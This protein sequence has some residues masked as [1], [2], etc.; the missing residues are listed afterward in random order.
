[1]RKMTGQSLRSSPWPWIGLRRTFFFDPV[2]K[3]ARPKI[4]AAHFFGGLRREYA[5]LHHAIQHPPTSLHHDYNVPPPGGALGPHR[6]HKRPPIGAL[7]PHRAHGAL[8]PH[9]PMGPYGPRAHLHAKR[10]CTGVLV[11]TGILAS[12]VATVRWNPRHTHIRS[13]N[14]PTESTPYSHPK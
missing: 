9:G 13:S 11:R 1:M 10:A 7:G 8:G 5:R 6:A 4:P 2:F 12:E 3:G 14:S